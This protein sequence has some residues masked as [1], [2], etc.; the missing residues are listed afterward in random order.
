M[1]QHDEQRWQQWR[2]GIICSSWWMEWLVL[3][4][5]RNFERV[6]VSLDCLMELLVFRPRHAGSREWGNDNRRIP[7]PFQHLGSGKGNAMHSFAKLCGRWS[8]PQMCTLYSSV[9]SKTI[10]PGLTW[11]CRHLC[12]RAATSARWAR[13]PRKS[14][15]TKMSLQSTKASIT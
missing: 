3:Q 4:A 7:L 2:V 11:W 12:W 9:S 5:C 6:W 8:I 15:A 14:S 13:K 10:V 1:L